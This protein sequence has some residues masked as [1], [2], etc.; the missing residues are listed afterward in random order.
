MYRARPSEEQAV[1]GHGE[2]DAGSHQDA[3]VQRADDGHDDGGREQNGADFAEEDIG[4]RFPDPYDP[5]HLPDRQGLQVDVV[6][7]QIDHGD[8]HGAY[9]EG[10]RQV[11][12]G[13]PDLSGYE[14][15]FLPAGKGPGNGDQGDAEC[16]DQLTEVYPLRVDPE[17]NG[18]AG[19]GPQPEQDEQAKGGDLDHRGYVGDVLAE[20]D[21]AVVHHREQ[22]D[23]DQR[24]EVPGG[25]RILESPAGEGDFGLEEHVGHPDG[26]DEVPGVFGESHAERGDDAGQVHGEGHPA[27]QE[28]A[29]RT[30]RLPQVDVLAA[31]PGYGGSQFAVRQGAREG[32]QAAEEPGEENQRRGGNAPGHQAGREEDPRT[33]H[34]ADD[35]HRRVE[36]AELPDQA[37][38]FFLIARNCHILRVEKG[39]RDGRA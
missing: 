27:E 10:A 39:P 13:F 8:A 4:R 6:H 9:D 37:S 17:V 16:D 21:A 14:G 18:L 34:D 33:D 25:K 12:R 3:G 24:G 31:C 29:E 11:P 5:G 20:G 15:N 1:P 2:V 23:Q 35:D 19:P 32:V 7:Q 30:V 28:P 36:Q 26:G 38:L 22:D